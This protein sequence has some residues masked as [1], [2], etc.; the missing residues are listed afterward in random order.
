M[1]AGEQGSSLRLFLFI[2]FVDYVSI[3]YDYQM[4]FRRSVRSSMLLHLCVWFLAVT[5]CLSALCT[6]ITVCSCPV[7]RS[8]SD[9]PLS[10][11]ALFLLASRR[12][13]GHRRS[14]CSCRA[15][16][17]ILSSYIRIPSSSCYRASFLT[18]NT[19]GISSHVC[20]FIWHAADNS[21]VIAGY[22]LNFPWLLEWWR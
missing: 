22:S 21:R 7:C 18:D 6:P 13:T 3:L 20:R 4:A 15:T 11:L 1:A 10:L 16:V 17:R 19:N 14:F 5:M 8:R 9:S 12:F 2:D